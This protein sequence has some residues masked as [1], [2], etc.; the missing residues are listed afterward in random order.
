MPEHYCFSDY[1]DCLRITYS[2]RIE[3]DT[4]IQKLPSFKYD[5]DHLTKFS[6]I[7]SET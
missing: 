7:F 6:H 2:K 4:F 1:V 5:L 3:V